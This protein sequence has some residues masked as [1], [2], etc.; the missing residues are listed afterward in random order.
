[1]VKSSEEH[2]PLRVALENVRNDVNKLT[3]NGFIMI[4]GKKINL[5]FSLPGDYKVSLK[6]TK[7]FK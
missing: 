2:E 3:N 6:H 7:M 4:D 1:M 5:T